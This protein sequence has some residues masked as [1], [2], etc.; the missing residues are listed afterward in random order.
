MRVWWAYVKILTT[1]STIFFN[2]SDTLQ[3]SRLFYSLGKL[4]QYL[5]KFIIG[6]RIKI[7]IPYVSKKVFSTVLH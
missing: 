5:S 7:C 6:C 2:R 4:K 3:H 1:V